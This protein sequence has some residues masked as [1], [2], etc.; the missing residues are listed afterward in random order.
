MRREDA[1]LGV[2]KGVAGRN[3]R[4]HVEDVDTGTGELVIVERLG[5]GIVVHDGAASTVDKDGAVLH[6]SE[7]LGTKALARGV[8]IGQVQAHDIGLGK[9]LLE[10]DLLDTGLGRLGMLVAGIA[11]HAGSKGLKE[12]TRGAADLAAAHDAYGLAADLGAHKTGAR[13]AGANGGIGST[14][15][16]QYID[17][18]AKGKLGH[19]HVGVAGTVAHLN[20]ALA[21][22]GKP[23]VIDAGK[24]D[25][26]HL[27]C[28]G[29]GDNLG[30]VGVVGDHDNLGALATACELCRIGRL[31]VKVDKLVA[32][33]LERCGKLVDGLRGY[34]QRLEQCNFHNAVLSLLAEYFG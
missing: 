4:L 14:H 5:Q 8:V 9:Q 27:E 7:L 25:G 31:G 33:F 2:D 30:R 29:A 10:R 13:L 15:L 6:L 1:V 28:V 22:G 20:T 18:K 26:D 32:S 12:A 21:A 23:H 19:A 11:Q 16:A 3:R 24:G 17:G 34:S